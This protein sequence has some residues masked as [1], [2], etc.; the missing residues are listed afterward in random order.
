MMFLASRRSLFKTP[1]K[2]DQTFY[3]YAKQLGVR[4]IQFHYLKLC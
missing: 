1:M 3:H 4:F 2:I